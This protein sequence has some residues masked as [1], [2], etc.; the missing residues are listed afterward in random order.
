MDVW[1]PYG[2]NTH[3]DK[4]YFLIIVDD[5]SRNT[6]TYL[7]GLK[8]D[9]IHVIHHFLVL[10]ENQFKCSVTKIRTDN[11]GEF[12]N[13]SCYVLLKKG[14]LSMKV[15]VSILLNKTIWLIENTDTF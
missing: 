4:R 9:A 2:V 14:E 15:V 5:F 8:S 12:F 13:E 10:I 1:G 6:W 11:G 3:D 7:L